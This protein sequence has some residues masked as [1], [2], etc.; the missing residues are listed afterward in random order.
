[1]KS[2][3]HEASTK[4]IE[5][6]IKGVDKDGS[7]EIDFGE[8][9]ALM[10]D[11]E[12]EKQSTTS[13]RKEEELRKAFNKFDSDHSGYITHD[14]LKLAMKIMGE[15]LSEEEIKQMME[16]ADTDGDGRVDFAEFC[17]MMNSEE[18]D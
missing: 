2:L 5:E 11:Q 18:A 1:M 7:G 16:E 10:V 13:S 4:V 14:E 15:D 12:K 17:K 8:F 6:I 9:V 3:G